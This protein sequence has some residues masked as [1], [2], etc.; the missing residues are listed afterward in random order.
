MQEKNDNGS[1]VLVKDLPLIRVMLSHGTHAHLAA[2]KCP[3][4]QEKTPG[5]RIE[6]VI[7]NCDKV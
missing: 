4:K 6:G 5:T 3:P 2:H 7:H 1:K